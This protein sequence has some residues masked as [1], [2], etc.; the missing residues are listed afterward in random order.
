M[1]TQQESHSLELELKTHFYNMK[2]TR[3]TGAGESCESAEGAR[4]A[5]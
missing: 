1:L 3:D 4:E 2:I 5:G